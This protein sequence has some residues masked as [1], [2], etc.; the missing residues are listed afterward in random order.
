M[1]MPAMKA[2]K[3]DTNAEPLLTMKSPFRKAA[4]ETP[5]HRAGC[6]LND[7]LLARSLC[8]RLALAL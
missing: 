8:G 1:T 5:R 7:V 2:N 4:A 3:I 6:L